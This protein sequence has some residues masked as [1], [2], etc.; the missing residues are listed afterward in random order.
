METACSRPCISD[1]EGLTPARSASPRISSSERLMPSWISLGLFA[2]GEPR[3]SPD[4][5]GLA[6]RAEEG[7]DV[8][9][10]RLRLLH[11]RE[12][13]AARE[14]GPAPD[15]EEGLLRQRTRRAQHLLGEGGVAG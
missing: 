1:Q 3:T 7:G 10:Q 2:S 14:L 15:V 8:L 12:M 9:R 4:R 13:P 6:Q 5:S 11:R